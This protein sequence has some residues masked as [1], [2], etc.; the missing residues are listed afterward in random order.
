[1]NTTKHRNPLD[2]TRRASPAKRARAADAER[3]AR[4]MLQDEVRARRD[5]E[6]AMLAFALAKAELPAA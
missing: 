5:Q 6:R 2:V 1:M 4:T 3:A